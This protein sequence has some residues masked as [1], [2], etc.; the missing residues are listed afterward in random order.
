MLRAI[1]KIDKYKEKIKDIA[2]NKVTYRV[3]NYSGPDGATFNGQML[4]D[5]AGGSGTGSLGSVSISNVN[6]GSASSAGTEFDVDLSQSEVDAISAQ[7]R[8]NSTLTATM[9]GTISAGPV[10]FKVEVT[11]NATVTADAL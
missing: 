6:L 8:D 9:A 11:I 4:F 5:P 1:L 3:S 10:S 2:V 7:L